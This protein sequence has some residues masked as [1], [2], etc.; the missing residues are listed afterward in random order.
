MQ[1]EKKVYEYQ[2]EEEN[3]FKEAL[4]KFLP[5]WPLFLFLTVVALAGA[6]LY[7]RYKVPFYQAT[8]TVMIKDEGKGMYDQSDIM[9]KLN[10][11]SSN[12]VVENEMEVFRSHRLAKEVVR[13][14]HL[15]AP[16]TQEGKFR[17]DAAYLISPITF[18]V[19]NPDSLT[20]A[21]KVYF[22][23]DS[24]TQ[25]IRIDKQFYALDQ[26]HAT[27]YGNLLFTRNPHYNGSEV[28][29]TL[30]FSL[31]SVRAAAS[32]LLGRLSVNTTNKM[33]T[34]L[35][36]DYK[37]EVPLR[38]ETI[39]NELV[40]EYNEAAIEDKNKIASNT[41][42]FVEERLKYVVDELDAVERQVKQF[43]TNKNV[44]DISTQGRLFLE[45]V[46]QNDR[47]LGDLGMQ[48]AI[49]NQ[50]EDYVR[51][52]N[53]DAAIVPST[54]GVNDPVLLQLLQGLYDAESQ[55][56][57]LRKTT[58]ENYPTAVALAERIQKMRSSILE[59]IRS[60]RRNVEAGKTELAGMNNRFNSLLSALPEK[61]RELLNIT[62]Q[63]A[64]K[65]SI[66]TFLL[67]KREETALSASATVADGRILDDGESNYAPLG[68]NS[69]TIYLIALAVAMG[70]G[71]AIIT[72]RE[73]LNSTIMTREEIEKFTTVP[74]LG[75][76]VHDKSRSNLVISEG[77]RSFIAEQFR[78][79][80]TSLGYLGLNS[81][82]KKILV[83]STVSGDGKS[84]FSLN[85]GMSLAL[86]G[87]RVVL[88]ELDLRK[89]RLSKALNLSQ[90]VG[91]SDYLIG[92][93]KAEQILFNSGVNANLFIVPSGPLP[94]N[95]SELITNGQ[96]SELFRHLE[97]QFD[98]LIIDTAP[99][100]PVSDAF[101]LAPLCDATLY[102]VRHNHTPINYIKKLNETCKVNEL[103]NMAI[104]FNDVKG[105]G[106]GG[107]GYHYEYGYNNGYSYSQEKETKKFWFSRRS[108]VGESA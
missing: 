102:V 28:A 58:S 52:R 12:K 5:Y 101:L 1:S 86:I 27:P 104:I 21:K 43:K 83:T 57:K 67:Q 6:Y 59:N 91:L 82:K 49:L 95:P 53:K 71:V 63:Q 76:L 60:Q 16:V 88:V 44:V 22:S 78:Y 87:K 34:V 25:K 50:V 103:K 3:F 19:K 81:R 97:T 69:R 108:K 85:L 105:R 90:K 46:G 4:Q 30:Y 70:L 48:M 107:Y 20:E 96:L 9:R 55:Y 2:Q 42:K 38:A 7:L 13:N 62:R 29:R 68:P 36:L 79:L 8:A 73:M 92:E 39:L 18:Q 33:A 61:E 51:G 74:I 98:Y 17:S 100:S 75:E 41:L 77:K 94:P 99:V 15:Y 14:L 23:F 64:I 35:K 10:V 84:F 26:W 47:K 66:Y 93:K 24:N 32:G 54:L 89:P 80:R 31:I 72:L 37:D 65:S 40:K 11:F 106:F 56:D 45:G